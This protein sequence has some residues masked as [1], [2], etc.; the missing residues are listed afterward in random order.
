MRRDY[1]GRFREK[2]LLRKSKKLTQT[3]KRSNKKTNKVAFFRLPF[4]EDH[5][6]PPFLKISTNGFLPQRGKKKI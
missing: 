5:I 1:I 2:D 3:G 6:V 4:F